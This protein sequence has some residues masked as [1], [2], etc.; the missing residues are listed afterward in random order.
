ME[1]DDN[2]QSDGRTAAQTSAAME[3]LAGQRW[4]IGAGFHRPHDPFLVSLK[5]I[6]LF[7][8]GSLKLNHDPAGASP[9]LEMASG[10]ASAQMVK[11]LLPPS[12]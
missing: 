12:R 8:A 1:G 6:A 7:P 10:G 11:A 9:L 2:D 4:F 3:K 5:Y